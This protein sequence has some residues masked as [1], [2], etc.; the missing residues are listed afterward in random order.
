MRGNK[1]LDA[2]LVGRGGEGR[3]GLDGLCHRAGENGAVSTFIPGARALQTGRA[4]SVYV[5][6]RN[7]VIIGNYFIMSI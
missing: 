6:L 4:L 5:L 1:A 2:E 3:G 7:K